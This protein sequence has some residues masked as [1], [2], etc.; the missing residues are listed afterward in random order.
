MAEL[1]EG[2]YTGDQVRFIT[3]A[4]EDISAFQ[5]QITKQYAITSRIEGKDEGVPLTKDKDQKKGKK[6]I[7]NQERQ[8]EMLKVLK[9]DA[10]LKQAEL[11]QLIKLSWSFVVFSSQHLSKNRK[12]DE[13][14]SDLGTDL[15][16][17]GK[18]SDEER[19]L[20]YDTQLWTSVVD[21][22]EQKLE[23][24][25]QAKTR[26]TDIE[27]SSGRSND[28]PFG[29]FEK[30]NQIKCHMKLHGNKLGLKRAFKNDLPSNLQIGGEF[31]GPLASSDGR[32]FK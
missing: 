27:G 17:I 19:V 25:S 9:A 2:L 8:Q 32:L 28:L 3:A 22:L 21:V 4:R 31:V 11:V 29:T 13:T 20:A 18:L 12:L 26:V 15:S 30:L 5:H 23:L 7:S 1:P 14:A 10:E 6:V 16:N 24:L